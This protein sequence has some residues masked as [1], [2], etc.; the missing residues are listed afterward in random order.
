ML[1][2]ALPPSPFFFP[3]FSPIRRIIPHKVRIRIAGG[4]GEIPAGYLWN[5]TKHV[6][7]ISAHSV[8]DI[9][10]LN[11]DKHALLGAYKSETNI[12]KN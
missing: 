12:T 2:C 5:A 6:I 3:E 7:A 8:T 9:K 10:N 4:S 11:K 1:I